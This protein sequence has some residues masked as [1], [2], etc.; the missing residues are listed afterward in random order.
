MT[1]NDPLPA[2][3]TYVSDT[4][5]QG[6]YNSTTGLWT[7]GN[8]ANGAGATL[9]I[10]ATVNAGTG[11][12]TIT[13]T[14]DNLSADQTDPNSADNQD[15][16]D[17]TVTAP[18]PGTPQ[19][20]INK[21]SDAG[22]FVTP[23]ETIT[24]TINVTNT[25]TEPLSGIAVTDVLP[26][27]TT[28]VPGSTQ[29]TAPT[30][31]T[32][33]D[34]FTAISYSGN[35]GTASWS[36]GWQEIGESDGPNSGRVVVVSSSYAASGNALRIGG[37]D[38]YMGS[39]GLSRQANLSGA[40]SATLTYNYRRRR[41]ETGG[42]V[43]L[44]VSGNGGST[45]TDTGHLRAQ[46]HRWYPAKRQFRYLRLHRRQHPGALHGLGHHRRGFQLLLRRQHSD[47]VYRGD[48]NFPRRASAQPG[49]RLQPL[50]G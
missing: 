31:D 6:T 19:L 50:C 18:A 26:T 45:W 40:A 38:V 37:D 24:Y 43:Y 28:Y 22:G 42:T 39:R 30:R 5:S 47:R 14:A 44:Q 48:R 46:R 35:N 36:N 3:V 21:A 13:N 33:R 49:Q 17:I 7:V 29:V 41:S 12:T 4:R 10:T 8:L 2:G 27:G 11:G 25:G 23:G 16:A 1:L 9:T 15:S 20:D 34:E 32:V